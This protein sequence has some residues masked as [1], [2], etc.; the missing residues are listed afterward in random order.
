MASVRQKNG[1]WYVRF[2]DQQGVWRDR[3]T[4]AATK[5]EA[6][7]IGAELEARAWKI[8]AGLEVEPVESGLTIEGLMAWW[9][10]T[11]SVHTAS[12]ERNVCNIRRHFTHCTLATLPLRQANSAAVETFLQGKVDGL[13]AGSINHLRMYLHRAFAAAIRAGLFE[14]ANPAA[15]VKRRKVPKRKPDFLRAEEVAAVLEA[16]APRWQPLFA[17][18]IFTGMR[19]GELL[20][21]YKRDVDLD[22][23]HIYVRHSHDRDTTKSGEEGV[24]PIATEL[25]PFLQTAMATSPSKLVFPGLDGDRMRE[26]AA[27]EK[28]LRRALARAGIVESYQHV[29][30]KKGCRHAEVQPDAEL[31][32]CPVHGHK[33][34]PKAQVRPIR[35]HDLR[36]TTASLLI[37]AGAS[38]ASVQR[39][40]RHSDPRVTMDVYAHLTPG[41]LRD[42]IDRLS[43]FGGSTGSQRVAG[44]IPPRGAVV[45]LAG[46]GSAAKRNTDTAT[47]RNVNT[48]LVRPKG[49]EPLTVGLEG[50]PSPVRDRLRSIRFARLPFARVPSRRPAT[51]KGDT[52]GGHPARG[53]PRI[54]SQPCDAASRVAL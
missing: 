20:G 54:P 47:A 34:W 38:T 51:A 17:T 15:N 6:K 22:G 12:H 4:P 49:F 19:K 7:R 46:E 18:A 37:I 11:Y 43:F 25:L 30:R 24:V 44:P 40:L 23:R 39:I 21:L 26:D 13:S 41:H 3:A 28:V 31:R 29:C 2:K 48:S 33:L 16:L 1:K 9:L 42:E 35:F 52:R 32:H 36:H 53:V 5:T 27:L 10:T 45:G 50:S 14:G 8:S